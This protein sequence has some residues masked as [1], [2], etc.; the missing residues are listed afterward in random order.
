MR[1]AFTLAAL[2]DL[3][4]LACDIKGSCLTAECREII[5]TIYGAKFGSE[6]GVI[7]IVKMALYVL[8]LSGA[9]FKDK[10]AKVLHGLR[11]RPNKADPV[12]WLRVW[13]KADGTEYWKM[14]LWYVDDILVIIKHPKLTIEGLKRKFKLKGDKAESP[15]MYLGAN[16]KV[17]GNE[18]GYKCW[19]MS[20][21]DYFNMVVQ[22]VEDQLK[23]INQVLPTKC[24][25]P[26]S[27]GYHPEVDEIPE[28]DEDGIKTYQ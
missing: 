6:K 15:T 28:L 4:I 21:E 9:A 23:V 2:N 7:M 3:Y 14:A 24:M 22:T 11:Y 27:P 13:T 1:I 12:V 10:L 17:F 19:T 18:S 25:V 20:S 5:Y 8:K 16:L 26:V